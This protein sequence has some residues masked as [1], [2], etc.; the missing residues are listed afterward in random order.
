[1]QLQF[2]RYRLDLRAR[3]LWRGE[4]RVR[5]QEKPFLVLV[6]LTREP[7]E[8]VTREELRDTLWPDGTVVDFDN[9]LNSAVT[10]LRAVLRDSARSPRFIETIPR[11]GYRFLS[12]VEAL[13]TRAPATQGTGEKPAAPGVRR[14]ETRRAGW[15]RAIAGIAALAAIALAAT[16]GLK[17][18]PQS[19][20]LDDEARTAWERGQFLSERAEK[21]DLARALSAFDA[22]L[23]AQPEFAPALAARAET[24]IRLAFHQRDDLRETLQRA[25][26]DAQAALTLD[27][28]LAEA[29]CSLG[30]VRLHVDWDIQ[31]A[32]QA[33]ERARSLQPEHAR[34]QLAT[35]SWLAAA[36]RLDEAVD[37]ARHAVALDPA[38]YL[39]RADLGWFLLAAGRFEEAVQE[40]REA[41][42]VEPEFLPAWSFLVPALEH[43][44]RTGEAVNAAKEVMRLSGADP[45]TID[46]LLSSPSTDALVAYRQ[47][48]LDAARSGGATH[49]QLALL[50]APLG[51]REEVVS[52]LA[53]S[54]ED[55][56]PFLVF[57]PGY[58]ELDPLRGDARFETML[59]HL[60]LS[61]DRQGLR[62]SL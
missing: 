33:I 40:S 10:S 35:A 52:R 57:L 30:L 15:L 24:R 51:H 19:A 50:H 5:M 20:V 38:S 26:S 23:E 55:R 16:T 28:D 62:S 22:V 47:W 54:A 41:L 60:G 14:P 32:G 2:D 18:T 12:T 61:S 34:I 42:A 13:E 21:D 43:L 7:G 59:L 37:A 44:G 45:A 17:S 3:E 49:L 6:A 31:G 48:R 1:M 11:V 8:V 56:D 9:N 29:H 27:D 4:R 46:T 53:L 39:V 36:G 58:R 25:G